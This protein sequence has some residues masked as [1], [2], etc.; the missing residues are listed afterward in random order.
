MVTLDEL[1]VVGH[2]FPLKF[3]VVCTSYPCQQIL[4]KSGSV[5]LFL[6][7]WEITIDPQTSSHEEFTWTKATPREWCCAVAQLC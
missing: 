6:C 5:E 4:D 1:G 7:L 2:S 3:A